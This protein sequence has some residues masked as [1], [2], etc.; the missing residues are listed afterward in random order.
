MN[1]SMSDKAGNLIYKQE[2]FLA[3]HGT[4]ESDA[5]NVNLHAQHL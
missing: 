1:G 2:L 5:I 4:R 3:L